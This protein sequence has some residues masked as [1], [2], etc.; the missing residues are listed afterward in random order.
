[1]KQNVSSRIPDRPLKILHEPIVFNRPHDVYYGAGQAH[2]NDQA[3]IKQESSKITICIVVGVFI[4]RISISFNAPLRSNILVT[5]GSISNGRLD[6]QVSQ[7]HVKKLKRW[8]AAPERP[9]LI[10]IRFSR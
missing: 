6:Q 9:Q 3:H 4:A 5:L 10:C 8:G 1:M 7:R 2:I